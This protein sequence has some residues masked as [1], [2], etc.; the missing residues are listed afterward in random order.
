M[1]PQANKSDEKPILQDEHGKFL[2]GTAAGPGRPAGSISIITRIKQKF[3]ESP[4][5]FEAYVAEVL[6]DPRLRQEVIRQIDGAPKQSVD[7]TSDGKQLAVNVI[8]YGSNP[9]APIQPETVPASAS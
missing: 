5:L 1:E 2:P 8:A 6:S 3:E 4:E 7:V 9:T